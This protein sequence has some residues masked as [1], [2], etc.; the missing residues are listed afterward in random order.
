MAGEHGRRGC[1]V[2]TDRVQQIADPRAARRWMTWSRDVPSTSSMTRKLCS[3]SPPES[4][5]VTMPGCLSWASKQVSR[6]SVD[7]TFSLRQSR[8]FKTLRAT[9]RPSFWSAARQTC[10]IP[11]APSHSIS[12]KRPARTSSGQSWVGSR[13]MG[14]RRTRRVPVPV[15]ESDRRLDRW[16]TGCSHGLVLF[17]LRK[18]LTLNRC[19]GVRSEGPRVGISLVDSDL[20]GVTGS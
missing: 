19:A 11:P 8:T 6:W 14:L 2:D 1:R 3:T 12:R 18:I 15:S 13:A 5:I 17:M 9:S 16:F 10:P 20:L 4:R 7:S